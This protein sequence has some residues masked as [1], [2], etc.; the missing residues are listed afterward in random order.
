M[1]VVLELKRGKQKNPEFKIV[2]GYNFPD[3]RG[4]RRTCL[5]TRQPDTHRAKHTRVLSHAHPHTLDSS[6]TTSRVTRLSALHR[7]QFC[8]AT[9]GADYFIHSL[10][11]HI[12]FKYRKTVVESKV[13]IRSLSVAIPT[14]LSLILSL[15]RG[16]RIRAGVY[17]E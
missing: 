6:G 14:T 15:S 10:D 13:G 16:Y 12:N 1:A 7:T 9:L 3:S 8:R 11:Y 2:P 4:Y 17:C 5:K